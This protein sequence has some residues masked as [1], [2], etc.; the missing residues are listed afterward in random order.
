MKK[1]LKRYSRLLLFVIGMGLVILGSVYT[2]DNQAASAVS[3]TI[4]EV[5]GVR[6]IEKEQLSLSN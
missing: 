2:W 3:E 4:D 5:S 1:I 6:V